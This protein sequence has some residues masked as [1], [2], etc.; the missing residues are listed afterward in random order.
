MLS[1]PTGALLAPH[2]Q[3][4]FIVHDARFRRRENTRLFLKCKSEDFLAVRIDWGDSLSIGRSGIL[5]P[6]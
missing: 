5:V 4:H 1:R 2:S 6:V 3:N